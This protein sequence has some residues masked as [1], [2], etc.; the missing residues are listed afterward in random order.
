MSE[1]VYHWGLDKTRHIGVDPDQCPACSSEVTLESGQVL[2][3]VHDPEKCSGE[4]CCIHNP[5][6]HPLREFP[7]YWRADRGMMERICPHGIGHPD[8]DDINPDTV[9]GC[10]GCCVVD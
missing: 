6:D 1:P 10:D 4:F 7:R 5:S 8:P 2:T 9:H 3:K